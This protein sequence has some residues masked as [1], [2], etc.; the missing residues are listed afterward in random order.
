[1]LKKLK[2]STSLV[3]APATFNPLSPDTKMQILLTVLHTYLM[4]PSK[5]NLFKYQDILSLAITPIILI[6]WMFEQ[7]VIM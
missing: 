7:V 6:T 3:E 4:E 5:E 1:M 2:L